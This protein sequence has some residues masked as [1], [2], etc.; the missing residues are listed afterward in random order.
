MA[1]FLYAGEGGVVELSH[2]ELSRFFKNFSAPV[3]ENFGYL[4]TVLNKLSAPEP[5]GES[6]HC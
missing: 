5:G 6:Y 1:P 4:H 3:F 2:I